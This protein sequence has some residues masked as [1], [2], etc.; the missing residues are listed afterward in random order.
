MDLNDEFGM[1]LFFSIFEVLGGGALGFA[2][3]GILRRDFSGC[4]FL[5]WGAGFAGIPLVIG[6]ATFL[7]EGQATYFYAQL[8]VF[9][10]AM[11]TVALLPSDLFQGMGESGGVGIGAVVGAVMAMVGGAI[12]LL[13]L[14]EGFGFPMILG[15]IFAV[16]GALILSGTVVRVIREL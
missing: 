16:V 2:L 8:F 9:L 10:A 3:R 7:S 6:A 14:K 12:I 4:F 13:N 15:G 1:L 11:L 5:I